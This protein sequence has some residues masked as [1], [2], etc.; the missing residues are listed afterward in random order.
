MSSCIADGRLGIDGFLA[1]CADLG[2]A[3]AIEP[4]RGEALERLRVDAEEPEMCEGRAVSLYTVRWA[5]NVSSI[6]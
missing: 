2:L 4:L 1:S 6:L 3:V 5:C